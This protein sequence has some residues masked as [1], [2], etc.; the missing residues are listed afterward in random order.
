MCAVCALLKGKNHQY[1]SCVEMLKAKERLNN[2]DM[3]Y[4]SSHLVEMSY[5]SHKNIMSRNNCWSRL[6]K[7]NKNEQKMDS[8]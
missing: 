5:I 8:D 6:G 3:T 7:R 4:I 1:R 2:V